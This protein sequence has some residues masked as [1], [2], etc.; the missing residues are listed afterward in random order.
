MTFAT[1]PPSARLL[2]ALYAAAA[3]SFAT[4]LALPYIGE[5][6]IYTIVAMEMKAS[7][8]YLVSTLYGTN[9]G[10]PPLFS[11]LIIALSRGLGWE[12]VLVAAR[13]VAAVATIGTG[14][15]LAWLVTAVTGNKRLAAFAALVYLT[16]DALVYHGW[17]A[18]TD[19]LFAFFTFAAIA[20][21][22]VAAV[23]R[24]LALAWIAAAAVSCAALAKG[25]TCYLFYAV[26]AAVLLSRRDLR[27]F[28][29]RPGVLLPQL[30]AATLFFAWYQVLTSGVQQGTAFNHTL[31]K[32]RAFD[33]VEHLHQL[34]WFP[35][36]IALRFVPASVL[37]AYFWLRREAA[38]AR[39]Q[40]DDTAFRTAAWI[41]LLNFLPYW[42]WPH[43][44]TRY[45]MPL[46]PLAAYLLAHALWQLDP[47]RLKWALKF[48]VA[49]IV[50]K[51][52]AALW[53]FPAY[54]RDNRGDYA[55]VARQIDD[56]ARGRA[57]YATDVS[58]TGLSVAAH[59]DARRIPREPLQWPPRDW[60][61]GFVLSHDEDP[62]FGS[63]FRRF[64]LGRREVYLLCRGAACESGHAR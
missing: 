56:L 42:L 45:V 46:Y 13:V 63:T 57:L 34:W 58:A 28:L 24:S 44:G 37:V 4:T 19:P 51:Y 10:Q 14:L 50:L 26:A 54:Q 31:A 1:E 53:V 21:L 40:H 2:W 11:W 17:L 62:A 12:N 18:Y 49:T 16:S 27:A 35:L 7:G 30:V 61:S 8:D 3:L 23:R 36:E 39:D 29:T 43:T 60:T 64:A 22:W 9:Q 20:C 55:E 15:V 25:Q 33:V 59:I 48:L 41:A 47:A 52:V 6:G 32:L 38:G 5:E